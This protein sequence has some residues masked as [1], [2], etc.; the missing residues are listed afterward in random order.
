[1]EC[2]NNEESSGSLNKMNED[3]QR[4]RS[5]LETV[6]EEAEGAQPFLVTPKTD[7][8][9]YPLLVGDSSR[10]RLAPSLDSTLRYFFTHSPVT[11]IRRSDLMIVLIYVIALESGLIPKGVSMPAACLTDKYHSYRSFD[12]RLVK[13]FATHLPLDC[14]R[15]R[16]GHYR[17]EMELVHEKAIRDNI[18]VVLLAFCSGDLLIVN[19]QS[20]TDSAVVFS[21]VVPI[22]FFVP[23][24]N[25]DRLPFCYQYLSRLSTKLKNELFV[26]F[27][28]FVYHKYIPVIYPSMEGLPSELVKHITRCLDFRTRRNLLEVIKPT[29][30]LIQKHTD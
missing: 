14:F 27:R 24:I 15:N 5:P 12:I 23:A 13:H 2:D 22:N 19:L 17:L 25:A 20:C 4:S 7:W 3:L 26:P 10:V 9:S 18:A 6:T 21:T 1:M 29:S 28:S 16:A 30:I 8:E 11:E